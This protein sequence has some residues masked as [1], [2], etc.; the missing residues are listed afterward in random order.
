MKEQCLISIKSSRL[1]IAA[2]SHFFTLQKAQKL[3]Q[4]S[5]TSVPSK[6]CKIAFANTAPFEYMS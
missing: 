6:A 2:K 3:S 4:N 1:G 5:S